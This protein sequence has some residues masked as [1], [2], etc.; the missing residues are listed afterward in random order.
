MKTSVVAILL[1]SVS[2]TWPIVSRPA[3]AQTRLAPKS[4]AKDN[5]APIGRTANGELVCSLKCE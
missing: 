4:A 2:V 3:L 5:C 1:I